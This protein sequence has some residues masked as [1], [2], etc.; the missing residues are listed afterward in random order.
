METE[1]TINLPFKYNCD[2]CTFNT[3]NLKDYKRHI[4]TLKHINGV[5]KATLGKQEVFTNTHKFYCKKC[6]YYCNKK[7][8]YTKHLTTVKHTKLE[9]N[10]TKLLNCD[11]C[12]KEFVN[13]S[14]L[15]KHKKKCFTKEVGALTHIVGDSNVCNTINHTNILM[16]LMVEV[17]K[18]SKEIQNV[19]KEIA[20]SN[21]I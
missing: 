7:S 13:R 18:Q 8:S 1:Q 9:D 16:K 19:L 21:D 15:W 12:N 14:G 4:T 3:S 11:V 2:I 6:D 10:E 20:I 17:I 5:K